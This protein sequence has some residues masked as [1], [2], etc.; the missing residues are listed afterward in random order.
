MTKKEF[1]ILTSCC[2]DKKFKNLTIVM[3]GDK[4]TGRYR[5]TDETSISY[6]KDVR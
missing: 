2:W 1:Q 4:Y 6:R 5:Y 3:T